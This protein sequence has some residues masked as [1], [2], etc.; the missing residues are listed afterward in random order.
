MGDGV[1]EP[2]LEPGELAQDCL[3][4]HVQPRVVD[5]LSQA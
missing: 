3:A 1:V 5:A 2:V 4:A